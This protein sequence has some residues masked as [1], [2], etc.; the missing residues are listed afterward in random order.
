M[1]ALLPF[2]LL[3]N[4]FF[5][6]LVGENFDEP[7]SYAEFIEYAPGDTTASVQSATVEG[8][9][10]AGYYWDLT[11]PITIE[12]HT[13][14][15]WDE[16]IAYATEQWRKAYPKLKLKYVATATGPC[17]YKER[18][19]MICAV[20]E[21]DDGAVGSTGVKKKGHEATAGK[22]NVVQFYGP[23]WQSD[24]PNSLST[25]DVTTILHELGHIWGLNH[26]SYPETSVMH[27][28]SNLLSPGSLDI[29]N[30]DT[31]YSGKGSK[32]NKDKTKAKKNKQKGKK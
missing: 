26:N 10:L 21:L 13:G 12:N 8:G 20:A 28:A 6:S 15:Q 29:K 31:I 25:F 1:F 19:V 14:E 2:L 22:I 7:I 27:P 18:V 11:K 32:A 23:L 30:L 24:N 17:E 9:P 5:P 4:F 3:L 16:G